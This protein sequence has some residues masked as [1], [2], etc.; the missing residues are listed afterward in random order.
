MP[1]IQAISALQGL[2]SFVPPPP[3][4]TLVQ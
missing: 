3:P 2:A 1:T 4:S